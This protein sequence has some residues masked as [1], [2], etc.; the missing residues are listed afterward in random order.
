[1]SQWNTAELERGYVLAS[2]DEYAPDAPGNAECLA[3]FLEWLRT[4]GA[5]LTARWRAGD[6]LSDLAEP[7]YLWLVKA[8]WIWRG[9]RLLMRKQRGFDQADADEESCIAYVE[10][11]EVRGRELMIRGYFHEPLSDADW[12]TLREY[13]ILADAR[14]LCLPVWPY[15]LG[16]EEEPTVGRWFVPVGFEM[17]DLS[18]RRL[19]S[20]LDSP[21]YT[22]LPTRDPRAI[23]RPDAADDFRLLFA[24]YEARQSDDGRRYVAGN[25]PKIPDDPASVLRLRDFRGKKPVV[26]I[27]ASATDCFWARAAGHV[28]ALQATW[29]DAVE[30]VWLDIRLWDFLIHSLDTRNYFLPDVGLELPP[31]QRTYEE[32]ARWSKKLYMLYPDLALTCAVDAPSDTTASMLHEPGGSARVLLVDLDG[33]VA[34]HSA[35]WG[36]W[37]STRPPGRSDADAWADGVEREICS[38]LERGGRFDPAHEPFDASV[39]TMAAAR[40]V[41]EGGRDC[42]LAHSRV[43]AVDHDACTV[44]I[45]A[46]PVARFTVVDRPVDARDFF[47]DCE[48]ITV[49]VLDRTLV[50]YRNAPMP[51][52]DVRPGD[53]LTGP[54]VRLADGSWEANQMHM[55]ECANPPAEIAQEKFV[56]DTWMTGRIVSVDTDAQTCIVERRL[57]SIAAM[58][59]FNFNRNAGATIQLY[60]PAKV[61]MDTVTRWVEDTEPNRQYTFGVIDDTMIRLNGQPATLT[62]AEPGDAITVSYDTA[63]EQD[64]I[65]R[66]GTLRFSRG[67]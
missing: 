7:Q 16:I 63:E 64:K 67:G 8:A 17:P 43:T 6:D 29:G 48:D 44:T 4:D 47:N 58:K 52:T 65:I 60:G 45:H 27:L 41:P 12:D 46:R 56:G 59:G 11:L 66:T 34:W 22:D 21:D 9:D 51:W 5:E 55:V 40:P 35:A 49:R 50:T 32:R 23:M 53:V 20:V 36:W 30:F 1:M 37:S 61:N 38:L 26:L 13:R 57:P 54:L 24:G 15:E 42:W 3:T 28:R 33:R 62:D 31:F 25:P 39:K 14:V 10:E 19:G 2:Q 18:W